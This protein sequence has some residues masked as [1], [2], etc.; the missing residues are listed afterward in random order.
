M[1]LFLA[2]HENS[3]KITVKDYFFKKVWTSPTLKKKKEK[4]KETTVDGR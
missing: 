3:T 4:E 2:Y 1:C